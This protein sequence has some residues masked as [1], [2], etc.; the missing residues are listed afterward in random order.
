MTRLID[1]MLNT[2]VPKAEAQAACQQRCW[3][4]PCSGGLV[5]YCCIYTDC[6]RRCTP[7]I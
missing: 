2:L 4:T 6:S 3:T 5:H 1:R 7:C